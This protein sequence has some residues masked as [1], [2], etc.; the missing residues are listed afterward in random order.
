VW[1]AMAVR[2]VAWTLMKLAAAD[3]RMHKNKRTVLRRKLIQSV[4]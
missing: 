3:E 2:R 4:T 1:R